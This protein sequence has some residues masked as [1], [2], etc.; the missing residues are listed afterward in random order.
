MLAET[1]RV[2][3]Q[4]RQITSQQLRNTTLQEKS[5]AFPA[6][7][8]VHTNVLLPGQVL[9]DYRAVPSLLVSRLTVWA[10]IRKRSGSYALNVI[11]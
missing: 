3:L 8:R 2:A 11:K 5:V 1:I 10:W 6:D 9:R 4:G 7:A